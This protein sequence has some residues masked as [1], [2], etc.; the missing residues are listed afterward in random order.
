MFVLDLGAEC[1]IS[2][3]LSSEPKTGNFTPLESVDLFH[4]KV[5][6]F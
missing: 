3:L 2:C 6:N 1:L 4:K 5:I